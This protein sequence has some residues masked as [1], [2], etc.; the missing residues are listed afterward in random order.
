M[1]RRIRRSARERK[2]YERS[3]RRRPAAR[4]QLPRLS[5]RARLQSVWKANHDDDGALREWPLP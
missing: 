2:V 1:P 5:G 3:A 4:S